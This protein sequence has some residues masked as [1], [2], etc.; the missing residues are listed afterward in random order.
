MNVNKNNIQANI[1]KGHKKKHVLFVS[2]KWK[3]KKD[4]SKDVSFRKKMIYWLVNAFEKEYE[5]TSH[6][7]QIDQEKKVIVSVYLSESGYRRLALNK[8]FHFPKFAKPRSETVFPFKTM[9]DYGRDTSI[10][11]DQILSGE[12]SHGMVIIAADSKDDIDRYYK[13]IF[14]KTYASL[15]KKDK[16]LKFWGVRKIVNRNGQ[17]YFVGPLGFKDGIA[18]P[19]YEDTIR[20]LTLVS[21]ENER[22]EKSIVG[23]FAAFIP[24]KVSKQKFNKTVGK[25]TDQIMQQFPYGIQTK[26]FGKKDVQEYAKSLLIGRSPDGKPLAHARDYKDE[27][28]FTYQ[29]DQNAYVCPFRAHARSANNRSDEERRDKIVRR[30]LVWSKGGDSVEKGLLFL[31]YHYDLGE[32]VI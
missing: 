8:S 14:G 3:K 12:D 6:S 10:R 24:L 13:G 29:H 22:N 1:L 32:P 18:N 19:K 30:G 21:A 16:L 4:V 23:T 27:N 25:I 2:F 7:A 11:S 17:R 9:L 5:L 20:K 15:F 26:L 28:L 31:S